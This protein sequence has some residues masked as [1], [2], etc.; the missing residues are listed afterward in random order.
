MS[1]QIKP[2]S[3][4]D[5]IIYG[6]GRFGSTTLLTLISLA[7]FFLYKEIYL[8]D[9]VLNGVANAIGKIAIAVSSIAMGYISDRFEHKK[10]GRRKPF[11][12]TGSIFLAVSFILLFFPH[13]FVNINDQIMLFGY[14]ALWLAAFNFFYGYLLTPYQAWLPEITRPHERV[15]VSGYENFFNVLG[16]MVGMG[17]SLAIPIVAQTMPQVLYQFIIVVAIIEILL[18]VPP[19]LRL[20]EPK[21]P[22][23]TQNIWREAISVLRDRNFLNWI[24]SRGTMSMGHTIM[25]T[26]L[27]GFLS[28]FLQLADIRYI[29]TAIF[30]LVLIMAS[31]GFWVKVS[32]KGRIK[33]LLIIG[34]IL[35][36][37]GLF[38]I[39]TLSLDFSLE[40]KQN[41]AMIYLTLGAF[42]LSAYWILNY[43]ILANII[44]ADTK[45]GGKSRAGTYT[46]V[47][48][49]ILNIFQATGYV[50][51]G[52]IFEIFGDYYGYV[53][54]GPIAAVF[55]LLGTVLFYFL[56][57]PEP[58][59]IYKR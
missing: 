35:M 13:I 58:E 54:W 7:T 4:A 36:I 39:S 24:I 52:Y 12:L 45:V 8:L 37:T 32:G 11:V 51:V 30:L 27:L 23:P 55:V 9:D 33:K 17:G 16:N 15:E 53:F 56:V 49:V 3:R 57:D 34:N 31:F 28:K 29:G 40:F 44:D 25:L 59:I 42:G 50:I 47:D 43:A 26:V 22:P 19:V 41:L 38:L 21:V 6:M 18:Y 5:K 48:G 14:E 1:I 2:L 10:L 46:G 20:Q